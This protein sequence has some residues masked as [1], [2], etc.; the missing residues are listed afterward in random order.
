MNLHFYTSEE[1]DLIRAEIREHQ[2]R[3]TLLRID[4]ILTVLDT[5]SPAGL[6]WKKASGHIQLVEGKKFPALAGVPASTG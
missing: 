6:P 2:H 4:E 5:E 3:E 1:L